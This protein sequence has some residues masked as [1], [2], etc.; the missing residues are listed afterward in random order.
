MLRRLLVG[1]VL[2]AIVGGLLAAGFVAGLKVTSF[3][4]STGGAGLA[5]LA[6]AVAGVAT[7][8]VAG[9]PIWAS[10]ARVEAGLKAFFGALIA[11]GAIFALRHWGASWTLDLRAFG[12]GG[13]GAPGDLPA[14]SL[15]LIGATLG[16]LFELDNTAPKDGPAGA[17]PRKRVA[18]QGPIAKAGAKSAVAPELDEVA[19]RRDAETVS[20]RS[21]R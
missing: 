2:G 14:V 21:K 16:A 10:G 6:A 19:P 11:A 3:D 12:G 4:A 13:P 1:L 18:A 5:Y 20:G 9:K 7:G 17:Q 8:L 15:P